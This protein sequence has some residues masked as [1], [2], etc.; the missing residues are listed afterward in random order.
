MSVLGLSM[1]V[2]GSM[3]GGGVCID[4]QVSCHYHSF[5][6]LSHARFKEISAVSVGLVSLD[7]PWSFTLSRIFPAHCVYEFEGNR[8]ATNQQIGVYTG[9]PLH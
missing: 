1:S 3:T 6:S 7:T 8:H 4:C 5:L 9:G 2:N